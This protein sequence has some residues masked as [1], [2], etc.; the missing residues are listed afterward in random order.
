MDDEAEDDAVEPRVPK[1]QSLGTTRANPDGARHPPFRD[2]RHPGARLDTP[3]PG[4]SLP[5]ERLGKHSRTT[6]DVQHPGAA[7]LAETDECL[8]S[9]PPGVVLRS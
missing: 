7:Q 3:D 8:E 6:A 2:L 1:R 5:G 9:R 4:R